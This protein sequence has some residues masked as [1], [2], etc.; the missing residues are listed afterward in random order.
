MVSPGKALGKQRKGQRR[1]GRVRASRPSHPRTEAAIDHLAQPISRAD[2][3]SPSLEGGEVDEQTFVRILGEAVEALNRS[4]VPYAFIGG[5]ASATFGRP[6][7]THDV[8]LFVRPDHADLAL[9][10]LA[11]AGFVTQKTDS[12]WLYKALKDEV[13]VDLIFRS[14]GDMYLDEEMVARSSIQEFK[15]QKLRVVAPEDLVVIK[16][17]VH[18]EKTPRHWYDALGIIAYAE[19]DWDY[20]VRRARRAPRRILS[21]LLYA[22]SNDIAV[23]ESAIHNLLDLIYEPDREA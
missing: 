17:V 18:D 19:L 12:F 1:P 8:D 10:A 21:L 15:G 2:D 22:Q 14:T 11:E 16:A 13:L 6:R 23:P 5:V 3:G 4:D 7:W 20:L 9:A